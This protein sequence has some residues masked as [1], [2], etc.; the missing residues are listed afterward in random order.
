MLLKHALRKLSI[1]RALDSMREHRDLCFKLKETFALCLSALNDWI[2]KRSLEFAFD[3]VN[4]FN[5][6]QDR[7]DFFVTRVTSF[8]QQKLV[9]NGFEASHGE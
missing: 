7:R 9:K 3:R 2:E 6:Y 5:D 8:A 4:K 1:L